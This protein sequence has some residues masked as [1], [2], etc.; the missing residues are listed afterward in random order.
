MAH[1]IGQG[2]HHIEFEHPDLGT[3][4]VRT[5]VDRVA[6]GY[7]LNVAV[8]PTYAGEVVQILSCY[9]DDLEITGTIQTYDD[10]L[11]LYTYFLKYV[12]LATQGDP[13]RGQ[14]VGDTSFNEFP[15]K[16]RYPHRGWEFEIMPTGVPGFR[17]GREVVAPEWRL[18]AYVADEAGD[19]GE[20]KELIVRE[21]EIKNAIGSTDPNFDENFGLQGKIRF[22]DEN[23]FSDPWTDHGVNF[24]EDRAN[25]FKQIGD[26]YS[27]LL[28]SY[29]KGDFD[30]IT[31]D[32]GSKPAFSLNPNSRAN[33]GVDTDKD[34]K[35]QGTT[36]QEKKA[37]KIR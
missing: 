21:V 34:P 2:S 11:T 9:V 1:I 30:A 14:E 37:S 35:G 3:L 28:P 16:M 26:Y 5:G 33:S 32:L 4:V 29:L 36:G 17:K 22:T 15:M 12:Q 23:P 31:G 24:A 13:R 6:W 10:M 18:Q 19:A 7:S 20:I 8:F 25:A 27:T